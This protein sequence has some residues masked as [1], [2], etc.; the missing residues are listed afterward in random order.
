MP[1]GAAAIGPA[2][3]RQDGPESGRRL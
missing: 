3:G 2:V 1:R